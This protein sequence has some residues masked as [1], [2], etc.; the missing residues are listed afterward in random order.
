MQRVGVPL[1]RRAAALRQLPAMFSA[2]PRHPAANG[3]LAMRRVICAEGR[4]PS[5]DNSPPE[6]D[7]I[8]KSES[9]PKAGVKDTPVCSGTRSGS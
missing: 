3:V 7:G 6:R 5:E 2:A 8:G 1:R 4:F 9:G